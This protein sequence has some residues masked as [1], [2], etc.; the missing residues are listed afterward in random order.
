M[1]LHGYRFKQGFEGIRE[2]CDAFLFK[3]LEQFFEINSKFDC[4]ADNLERIVDILLK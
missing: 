2:F 3:F 4:V 1:L